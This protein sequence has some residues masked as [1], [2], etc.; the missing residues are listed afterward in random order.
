MLRFSA[1]LSLLLVVLASPVVLADEVCAPDGNA[2]VIVNPDDR[3]SYYGAFA[4]DPGTDTFVGGG[5]GEGSGFFGDTATLDVFTFSSATGQWGV[6]VLAMNDYDRDGTYE[7][8]GFYVGTWNDDP[9][10]PAV[11]HGASTALP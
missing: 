5:Y 6:L 3:F 11:G 9:A 4:Y 2:C 10:I 8:A 1:L 7:D